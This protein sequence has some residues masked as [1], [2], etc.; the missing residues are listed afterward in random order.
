MEKITYKEIIEE[1]LELDVFGTKA[2][3]RRTADAF[4]DIIIS[5]LEAGNSVALSQEFGTFTI[6]EQA[7]RSGEMNGVKY[8]TPAKN[9]V[10]FKPSSKLKSRVAGN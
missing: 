2:E 6:S 8:S 9:V 3:A 4:L 10:K 5:K 1:F 7:A